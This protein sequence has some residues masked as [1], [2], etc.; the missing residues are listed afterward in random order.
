MTVAQVCDWYLEQAH[1]G[2]ILGRRG[3]PIKVST[4][5]MDRSRIETHIK[6]LI[7]RR[8]VRNLTANDIEEMQAGIAAGK[9]GKQS[10]STKTGAEKKKRPRGGIATGGNGVAARSLGMIRTIFEHARR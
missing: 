4:I 3:R 9:S 1:A 7:G 5:A 6:P 8:P 10:Q 2:R